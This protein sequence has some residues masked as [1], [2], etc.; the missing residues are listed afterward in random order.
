M[1]ANCFVDE[2]SRPP[3]KFDNDYLEEFN[4]SLGRIMSNRNAHVLI[5]ADFNCGDIEWVT[6]QVP[7]GAQK[8]TTWIFVLSHNPKMASALEQYVNTVQTLSSQGNFSVVFYNDTQAKH[9]IHS[10]YSFK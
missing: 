1:S 8:T 9:C 2:L 5:G 7:H 6:M 3:D 4:I 10:V